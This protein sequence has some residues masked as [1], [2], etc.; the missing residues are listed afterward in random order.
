MP[1]T[2]LVVSGLIC[3]IPNYLLYVQPVYEATILA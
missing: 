3:E 2:A 1:E